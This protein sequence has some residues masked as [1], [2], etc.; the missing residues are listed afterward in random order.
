[1]LLIEIT[2]LNSMGEAMRGLGHLTPNLL[3][4]ELQQFRKLKGY[5]PRVITAHV[6][7]LWEDKLRAELAEASKRLG[8]ELEVGYEGLT[9]EL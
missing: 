3:I 4:E 9:V 7:T 1:M 8:S 6:P 2:G 5:L